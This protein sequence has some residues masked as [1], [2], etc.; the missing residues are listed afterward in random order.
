MSKRYSIAEARQDLAAIIH[1]AETMGPVQFTRRGKGVAVLLSQVDYDRLIAGRRDFWEAYEA[2][3]A[4]TEFVDVD[5]DP[6]IF[7]VRDPSP[8]RDV[9]F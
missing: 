4:L 6:E 1:E 5:I 2:F 7:S 8:G 9:S 3:R